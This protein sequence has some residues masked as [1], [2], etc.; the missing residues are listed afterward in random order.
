MSSKVFLVF[1]LLALVFLTQSHVEACLGHGQEC[2][3]LK[4]GQCCPGKT[5]T[6]ATFTKA[7]CL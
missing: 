1:V 3:L 2:Y 7:M 5:C 6:W 4:R